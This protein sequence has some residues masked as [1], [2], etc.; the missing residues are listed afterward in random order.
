MVSRNPK[1]REVAPLNSH[2]L[3]H[4]SEIPKKEIDGVVVATPP[5]THVEITRFFAEKGI[6]VLVEKPLAL[7]SH[8]IESLRSCSHNILVDHIHL[9]SPA[10]LEIKKRA[11][12]E[13]VVSVYSIGGNRGPQ[14][15]YLPHWD[16][17]P[18]DLSMILELLNASVFLKE[19]EYRGSSPQS[20]NWK[21]FLESDQNQLI[22]AEF[23]NDMD[24]KRRSLEVKFESG[25]TL[26]YNDL[27]R[28]KLIFK[29]K[30]HQEKV[31]PIDSGLPLDRV[32]Q[33]FSQ[34]I[35]DLKAREDFGIS[36]ALKISEILEE[37]EKKV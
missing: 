27:S 37:M 35:R 11:G 10:F 4:Y 15:D 22:I 17:G 5:Q 29:D 1:T 20:G 13:K 18:H 23:G 34:G 33:V 36:L 16:Y 21:V 30:S 8:S 26:I 24:S 32:I 25:D 14:R 28:D 31:I 2:I 3:S 7:D 6:P 19:V 12:K 9:F